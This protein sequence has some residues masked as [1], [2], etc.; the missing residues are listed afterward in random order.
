VAEVIQFDAGVFS[1]T[2]EWF[3]RRA[4]CWLQA[5]RSAVSVL[6]RQTWDLHRTDLSGPNSPASGLVPE[7]LKKAG[8]SRQRRS[9]VKLAMGTV[10]ALSR[11][12]G[13]DR[14]NKQTGVGAVRTFACEGPFG[15][16]PRAVVGGVDHS[17][18]GKI[19]TSNREEPLPP[20]KSCKI[21][22]GRGCPTTTRTIR[23]TVR[24]SPSQAWSVI[25]GSQRERCRLPEMAD[26]SLPLAD[27]RKIGLQSCGIRESLYHSSLAI[28]AGHLQ[29]TDPRDFFQ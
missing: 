1:T 2:P 19:Q 13:R 3:S 18:I 14:R 20:T 24:Y 5:I 26:S 23:M 4:G 10:T 22:G 12:D 6:N 29:G 8:R 28:H 21:R 17:L 16:K 9:A 15:V 27:M 11:T 25:C 7:D